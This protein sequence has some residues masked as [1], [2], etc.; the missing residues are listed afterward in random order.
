[1]A[2]Y[3]SPEAFNAAL[4]HKLAQASHTTGR[5]LGQLRRELV[6][7]RFLARLFHPAAQASANWSLKGGTGLL[8]RVPDSRHTR[9]IDLHHRGD[10]ASAEAD[11]ARAAALQ[12]DPFRFRPGQPIP[13]TGRHAGIRITLDAYLGVKLWD[14]APIDLAFGPTDPIGVIDAITPAPIVAIDD[15]EPSAPI[16]IYPLPAQI[17]DKLCAMYDRYSDQQ[18]TRFHDL[19]DLVTVITR[20]DIPAGPT[21][22]AIAA[23]ST[24]RRIDLPVRLESPGSSWPAGYR[25]VAKTGALSTDLQSLPSALA[26]IGRCL[27]PLMLGSVPDSAIWRH[28][29]AAWTD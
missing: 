11:I 9:D 29:L 16:R 20:F 10:T 18:S 14:R 8:L 3:R 13:M 27:H 6:L 15:L 23:E 17:A 26:A 4:T 7:Q 5:N 24:H 2:T 25:V 28:Q 22:A 21:A 1:V 12:I 19:I